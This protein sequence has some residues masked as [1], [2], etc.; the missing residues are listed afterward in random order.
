MKNNKHIEKHSNYKV[1]QSNR[2]DYINPQYSTGIIRLVKSVKLFAIMHVVNGAFS[3][4][5]LK[6]AAGLFLIFVLPVVGIAILMAPTAYATAFTEGY[7]S[8]APVSVGT[9]VS[10]SKN[11]STQIEDSTKD[12]DSRMVGVVANAS[13]SIIDLQPKGSNIRVAVSGEASVLVTDSN[14]EIKKGDYLI[15]SPLAGI[16]AKDVTEAVASKYIGIAQESFSASSSGAQSVSASLSDGKQQTIHIGTIKA[17]ILISE[18]K[19]GQ[20]QQSKNF[21]TSLGEKL[22]GK[23]VS[24]LRVIASTVVFISVFSISGW[25]LNASIKGSFVSLGRNPL[26]KVSI[27]SNLMRVIILALVIF[28]AGLTAAYLVLAL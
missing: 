22:V 7:Q 16:A 23:Q 26:A 4:K 1:R 9:V 5:R 19:S 10:I 6:A 24:S 14:G 21:L 17:T 8:S 11:S 12:N 15:I 18:R 20:G 25:I 2:L 3:I 28:A 27:I 13:S